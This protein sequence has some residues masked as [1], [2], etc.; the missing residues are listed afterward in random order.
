MELILEDSAKNFLA[1]KGFDPK[2]GARPLRRAIQQYLEDKLSEEILKGTF[3]EGSKI[4][5]KHIDEMD[6]L[7]FIEEELVNDIPHPASESTTNE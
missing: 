3:K 6:Y 1:D 4:I 2:F 7:I 5:A